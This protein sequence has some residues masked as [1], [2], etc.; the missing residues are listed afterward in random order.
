MIQ[1]APS[2][3]SGHALLAGEGPATG[4][5]QK[6]ASP[7]MRVTVVAAQHGHAGGVREPFGSI[8]T[9]RNGG[10]GEGQQGLGCYLIAT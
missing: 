9:L 6:G 8:V 3:R 2:L 10:L 4:A 5:A 7:P 1:A